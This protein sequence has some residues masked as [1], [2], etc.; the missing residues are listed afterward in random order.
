MLGSGGGSRLCTISFAANRRVFGQWQ[1][2]MPFSGLLI[3]L[4]EAHVTCER[5]GLYGGGMVRD[6]KSNLHRKRR[7]RR[8]VLTRRR[9]AGGQTRARRRGAVKPTEGAAMTIDM[10][11]VSSLPWGERVVHQSSAT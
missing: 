2:A 10:S 7:P 8:M 3:E 11:A 4:P 1:S 5:T 6:A 9:C